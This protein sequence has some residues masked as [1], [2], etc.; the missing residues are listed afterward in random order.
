MP[1]TKPS[2]TKSRENNENEASNNQSTDQIN[3]ST[4]QNNRSSRQKNESSSQLPGDESSDLARSSIELALPWTT[5]DRIVNGLNQFSMLL[6]R[7]SASNEVKEHVVKQ[8]NGLMTALIG[9]VSSETGDEQRSK[10]RT[11]ESK[12]IEESGGS[13]ARKR[14]KGKK[15]AKENAKENAKNAQI[16]ENGESNASRPFFLISLKQRSEIIDQLICNMD[17]VCY[18]RTCLDESSKSRLREQN[19]RLNIQLQGLPVKLLSISTPD[20]SDPFDRVS[21]SK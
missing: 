13:T 2:S 17:A 16:V 8:T 11:E 19:N 21:T 1:A 5:R 10:E 3:Q 6:F 14:K 9:L 12:R 18:S 20:E 4:D 7:K 15:N